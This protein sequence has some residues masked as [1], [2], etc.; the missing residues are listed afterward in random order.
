MSSCQAAEL[1]VTV[2][3]ALRGAVGEMATQFGKHTGHTVNVR[4]ALRAR[5]WRR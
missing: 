1:Q 4:P 2:S 3:L 5:S